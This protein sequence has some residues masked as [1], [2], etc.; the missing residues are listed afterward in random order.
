VGSDAAVQAVVVGKNTIAVHTRNTNGGRY[1]DVGFWITI[2]YFANDNQGA[3][4]FTVGW[5]GPGF[6][7]TSI[8][9]GNLSH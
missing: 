9:A 2:E 7:Q 3:N 1:F 8:A 4:F 6:S 5:S